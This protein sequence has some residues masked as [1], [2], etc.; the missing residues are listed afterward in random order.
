MAVAQHCRA[1]TQLAQRNEH[2]VP[3]AALVGAIV[4]NEAMMTK[5]KRNDREVKRAPEEERRKGRLVAADIKGWRRPPMI[6]RIA[7]TCT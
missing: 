2:P 5:R 4:L 3:A 7:A 6:A 1:R